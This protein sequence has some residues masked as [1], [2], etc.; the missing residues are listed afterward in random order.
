M[1]KIIIGVIAVVILGG[2]AFFLIDS[3]SAD[4]PGKTTS[5]EKR[6]PIA[7]AFKI[8]EAENDAVRELWTKEIVGKGKIAGLQFDENWEDEDVEAGPLPALFLRKTANELSKDRVPLSLFLGSKYP[9]NDANAFS[10]QQSAKFEL[11]ESDGKPQFFFAKDI[12]MHTAM[13]SDIAVVDGCVTCHNTHPE[14]PKKDWKLGDM[15]G[16]TTWMYPNETVSVPELMEM[17]QALRKGFGETY[18]SYLNKVATFES[19]PAIGD[20]WPNDGMF[21]PSRKVFEAEAERRASAKTMK[22]I[23]EL[24]STD[25]ND[26]K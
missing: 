5:S 2:S 20:Q 4:S 22:R 7:E 6:I 15:M 18:Q 23:L 19:K 16:A 17:I 11:I 25:S 8:L 3:M 13:F 24:C 10:G 12:N 21:L 14:T 26:A 9:I 1:K